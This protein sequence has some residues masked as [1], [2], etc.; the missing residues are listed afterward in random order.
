MSLNLLNRF[1]VAHKMLLAFGTVCTL[2]AVLGAISLASLSRIYQTTKDMDSNWLP[3]SAGLASIRMDLGDARRQEFNA[4]ICSDDACLQR[5]I[6]ARLAKLELL[7]QERTRYQA[8][9]SAYGTQE[10][11]EIDAQFD[12][13]LAVYN[14]LSEKVMQLMSEGKR[15]EAILEL[16]NVSG[17]AF[18]QVA[19]TNEKAIVLHRSGAEAATADAEKLYRRVKTFAILLIL[20]II[21][22]SA[23][24][25][26]ML[27]AAICNP[28]SQ[29]SELLRRIADKDL[30]HTI[31]LDSKDEL[32]QMAQSL[33][34][35]VH[36][37]SSVLG[38]VTSSA[39]M[40]S[41]ATFGL[42]ENAGSSSRNAKDLSNQVQQVAA[43]SQEMTATISEISHNAERAA[44]ASR[45]SVEG[46]Q[47]GGKVMDE[48]A[49]TMNRIAASNMAVSH[50]I[51]T[52]GERSKQIGQVVTVIH[53]ISE[54]TNLLALNA[55]IE[56]ARA[57]EHGRGFAVVAGEVRRLA[58]RA[59]SSAGEISKMIESIQKDMTEVIGMVEGGRSDVEHGIQR[60]AD[61]RNA[62][63]MV[64]GLAQNSEHM[65]TMIATASHEQS[66]ASSEI[67]QTIG[68]MANIASET[69]SSSDQT[70]MAC[71]Q[72]V[73]LA[74]SLDQL[75]SQFRL[76]KPEQRY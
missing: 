68:S 40:L 52:L 2:C 14:P 41:A 23:L 46:A 76:A 20:V 42:T 8:I 10:S 17:P 55:A 51:A 3:A 72:L 4:V 43:T 45:N 69:A 11:Q 49:E 73:G 60:M 67:S 37:I 58:E 24:I 32:G 5:F 65:V 36:S 18:D 30:T 63:D 27:T 35:T 6:S 74:N 56:S 33:N 28:L 34:T 64:I 48:T 66:A 47:Q 59:G 21:A 25:G 19:A 39:E 31:D 29:A 1:S 7:H 71:E 9:A 75:V 62:I 44:E 61:A 26:R 54:Q 70:A 50:R 13:D 57:G 53:D 12:R 22:G 16:R 15:D 38:T